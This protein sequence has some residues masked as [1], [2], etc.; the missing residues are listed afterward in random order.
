MSVSVRQVLK[1]IDILESYMDQYK[2]MTQ[3]PTSPATHSRMQIERITHLDY[4]HFAWLPEVY[5]PSLLREVFVS[6]SL[7]T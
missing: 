2:G 3:T 1:V 4:I 6:C 7:N 5:S